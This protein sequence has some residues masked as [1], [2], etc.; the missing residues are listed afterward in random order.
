MSG[1]LVTMDI[2]YFLPWTSLYRG[3][4]EVQPVPAM[5]P[6]KQSQLNMWQQELELEKELI[7]LKKSS[8][9]QSQDFDKESGYPI[10]VNH[11][12]EHEE[13]LMTKKR[14][15]VLESMNEEIEGKNE[16]NEAVTVNE[17]ATEPDLKFSCCRKGKSY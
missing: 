10:H 13:M 1:I 6:F 5:S 9:P 7:N 17:E 16:K 14:K 11:F 3:K 12:T 8:E 4:A 15:T 2:Y